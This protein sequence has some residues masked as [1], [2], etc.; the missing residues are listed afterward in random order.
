MM[1]Q[2]R[3]VESETSEINTATIDAMEFVY[4]FGL[5]NRM[6]LQFI[7]IPI[8]LTV[9]VYLVAKN[10]KLSFMLL[11]SIGMKSFIQYEIKEFPKII[12]LCKKHQNSFFTINSTGISCKNRY[13]NKSESEI[14]WEWPE[15]VGAYQE[16]GEL[17][18]LRAGKE[19]EE[20]R[21]P[22]N[23]YLRLQNRS[24]SRLYRLSLSE[25]IAKYCPRLKESLG[26]VGDHDALSVTEPR[27]VFTMANSHTFTYHTRENRMVYIARWI[28]FSIMATGPTLAIALFMDNSFF[29]VLIPLTIFVGIAAMYNYLCWQSM[30]ISQVETDDFS[31]AYIK[32]GK[33]KWQIQWFSIG[34]WYLVNDVVTIK[35]KDGKMH[36]FSS[37][38]ARWSSLQKELE[39]R[40]GAP[41]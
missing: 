39:N 15:V 38:V 32:N 19:E 8:W 6:C 23:A 40:L 7:L 31:I 12:S 3:E 21:I 18:L 37:K 27:V 17:V 30:T 25:S 28:Q 10:P 26:Q 13:K 5:Q 34:K 11:P 2:V 35:T 41:H 22:E 1:Q 14:F 16:Q 36:K 29:R 24:R 9:S 4:R 33:L 20:L